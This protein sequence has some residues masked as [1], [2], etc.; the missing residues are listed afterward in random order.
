MKKLIVLTAFGLA[1]G[2][3]HQA[4]ACDP[5]ARA[6]NATPTVV[7]KAEALTT[8]PEAAPPEGTTTDEPLTPTATIAYRVIGYEC[9]GVSK[10]LTAGVEGRHHHKALSSNIRSLC[11][12]STGNSCE[13][14][15]CA[16]CIELTMRAATP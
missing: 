4:I 16:S 8:K 1:F 10:Q 5:G 11:G 14:R 13:K 6:A 2:T 12:G 3:A 9:G 7:A 15:D